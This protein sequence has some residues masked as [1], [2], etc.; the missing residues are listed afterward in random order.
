MSAPYFRQQLSPTAARQPA[1]IGRIAAMAPRTA[2]V[3]RRATVPAIVGIGGA[4]IGI[5]ASIPSVI[6]AGVWSASKQMAGPARAA[7]AT[8]A[9]TI[10]DLDRQ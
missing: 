8:A 5:G 4:I 10:R 2:P 9:T 7:I 6:A 3:S 1:V